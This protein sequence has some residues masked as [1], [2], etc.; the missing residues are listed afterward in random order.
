[1]YGICTVYVAIPVKS[2][3][4]PPSY[5]PDGWMSYGMCVH[6]SSCDGDQMLVLTSGGM[7]CCRQTFCFLWMDYSAFRPHCCRADTMLLDMW[8]MTPSKSPEVGYHIVQPEIPLP[9]IN[10][11]SKIIRQK[12]NHKNSRQYPSMLSISR[13]HTPPLENPSKQHVQDISPSPMTNDLQPMHAPLQLGSRP[14][15]PSEIILVLYCTG[16]NHAKLW[17]SPIISTLR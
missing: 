8:H 4:T 13:C 14:P 10:K 15:L 17:T 2:S 12:L 5:A 3:C 1:M 16:P 9:Q 6:D 11:P 7:L